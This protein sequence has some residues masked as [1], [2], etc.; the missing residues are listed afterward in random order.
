MAVAM[1][2]RAC[3]TGNIQTRM[4]IWATMLLLGAWAAPTEVINANK[5]SLFVQTRAGSPL[6][7]N[8]QI[9]PTP[10][11]QGTGFVAIPTVV[12]QFFSPKYPN[13]TLIEKNGGVPV[14]LQ[15]QFIQ[16]KKINGVEEV[17]W[18]SSRRCVDS[19]SATCLSARA[20]HRSSHI[21]D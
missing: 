11:D 2:R 15:L 19:L 12:T 4:L 18:L 20:S 16:V 14:F 5:T 8:A 21:R 7:V 6:E 13:S 10:N 9:K 17:R 3:T 1:Y